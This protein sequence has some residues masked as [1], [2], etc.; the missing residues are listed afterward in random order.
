MYQVPTICQRMRRLFISLLFCMIIINC[1]NNTQFLPS[2]LLAQIVHY[3]SEDSHGLLRRV[4]KQFN[5]AVTTARQKEIDG[6]NRINHILRH[7]IKDDQSFDTIF[8]EFKNI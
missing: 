8:S 1:K 3:H 2:E 6:V 4:N 5:H 7:Q